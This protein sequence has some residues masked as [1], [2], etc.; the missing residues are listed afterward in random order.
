MN[1][2]L[3]LFLVSLSLLANFFP[4]TVN[5]STQTVYP[6]ALLSTSVSTSSSPLPSN[7]AK[8]EIVFSNAPKAFEMDKRYGQPM[9]F[10]SSSLNFLTEDAASNEKSYTE[11]SHNV[12]P[13]FDIYTFEDS[14]GTFQHRAYGAKHEVFTRK[15]ADGSTTEFIARKP[16]PGSEGMYAVKVDLGQDAVTVVATGTQP[17]PIEKENF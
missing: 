17:I 14:S 8:F 5:R 15:N 1:S 6:S 16:E 3:C 11:E 10:L 13:N 2:I 9:E 4:F 7:E 12:I